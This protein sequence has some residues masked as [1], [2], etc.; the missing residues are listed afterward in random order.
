LVFDIPL[1]EFMHA[2]LL[3]NDLIISLVGSEWQEQ[4]L[5]ASN[6]QIMKGNFIVAI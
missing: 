6:A 3:L 5:L 4:K 1:L 2:S